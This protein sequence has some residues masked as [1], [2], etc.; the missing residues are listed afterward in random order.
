MRISGDDRYQEM[1]RQMKI[2]IDRCTQVPSINVETSDTRHF[3]FSRLKIQ[4]QAKLRKCPD[5]C[6]PSGTRSNKEKDLL[7][8]DDPA[9]LER[10]IRRGDF[11]QADH[12]E[13]DERKNNRSMHISVV[14]RHQDMP[15]QMK[16]NI[17]RCT[18]VPSIDVETVDTRH[19]GS[20]GLEAQVQAKLRK[21]PDEFL[22]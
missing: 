13:V 11:I 20:N 10:T 15:R 16:I 7:F 17:D 6:M 8:S 18:Q 3:V 14:D 1:P 2:N 9:H 22:T 12:V 21:F 4:G 19:F 5:E